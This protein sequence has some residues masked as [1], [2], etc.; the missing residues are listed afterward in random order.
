MGLKV[1][2]NWPHREIGPSTPCICSGSYLTPAST[3]SAPEMETRLFG[4][5]GMKVTPL[6]LGAAEIG[7]ENAPDGAVDALLGAAMDVGVNF[8]DT[9]ECY[10]DSEDKLGRILGSRRK[11]FILS[12]KCGHGPRPVPARKVTRAVRRLW[13]PVA[14]AAG[15]SL[16]DWNPRLLQRNIHQSLR[17]L[18]T[19]YIDLLHLHSCS[20]EVLR[21]G[22]AI[23][24]LL[25]ARQAGKVRHLGYSGD[26]NAA[27]YAVRCGY[28]DALQISVNIADQEAIEHTL[29][30]ARQRGMG[31][32][33]KR[34]VANGVWINTNRPALSYHHEYWDRLKRLDY[35]FLRNGERAFE[36]AL[37][38]TL[39]APGVHTAIVGTT[40]PNHW[41]QNA[42][43][44]SGGALPIV[45]FEAIRARWKEVAPPDWVGQQ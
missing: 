16:P 9:A 19:D 36:I 3:R 18:R 39:T 8:I 15:W 22:E 40:K 26:G 27:L 25:K 14:R 37:R 45:D 21:R 10:L 32:I 11:Q 35:G 23:E 31:V 13:R 33:A 4:K 17:R 29:P 42:E 38:F 41:K 2:M 43:Y 1:T 30:T 6:G 28:F 20:E 12:T 44:V 7:F 5:T 34:P 24:V